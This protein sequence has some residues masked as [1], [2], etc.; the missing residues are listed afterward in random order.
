MPSVHIVLKTNGTIRA[1]GSDFTGPSCLEAMQPLLE[2]LGIITEK[3]VKP[4]FY[5]TEHT[6]TLEGNH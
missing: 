6:L 2:K 4:E 5:A 1:E 3:T